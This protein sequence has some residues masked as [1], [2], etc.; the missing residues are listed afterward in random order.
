M[1]KISIPQKEIDYKKKFTKSTFILFKKDVDQ[2][3][4]LFNQGSFKLVVS[5]ANSL[6]ENFK[7]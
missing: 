7:K 5:V 2:L 3:L 4:T 1:L 6:M